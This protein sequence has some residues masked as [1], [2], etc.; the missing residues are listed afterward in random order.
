MD[1]EPYK[2]WV[3][4]VIARGELYIELERVR[5]LLVLAEQRKRPNRDEQ[6]AHVK[7]LSYMFKAL[8]LAKDARQKVVQNVGENNSGSTQ[9]SGTSPADDSGAG[10]CVRYVLQ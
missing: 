1:L 10:I 4:G 3:T 5:Q 7:N 8:L 6:I 9:N 2:K